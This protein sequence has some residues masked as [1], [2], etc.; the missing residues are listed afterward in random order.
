MDYSDTTVII[1]VKDEP[2]VGKVT[3]EVLSALNNCKVLVIYKGGRDSLN[4]K[5]KD[6]RLSIMQQKG[7]GKGVAVVQ[8]VKTVG[9]DIICFIDG[10]AT[11]DA[12][13]LKKAIK[14]V[15]EGADM[16]IGNRLKDMDRKAMP[17][18]IEFGNRIITETANLLYNMHI[19]DS[20]TGLRAMRRHVFNS[21]NLKEEYFGI[22]TEMNVRCKKAGY[23]IAEAPIK[24]YERIGSS[25]QMKLLDGIKLLLLD[26]KFLSD[27]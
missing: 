10:D 15:R 1:P 20:Q 16:A 4:I 18:Y 22:E 17:F 3:K 12:R 11:Y 27:N 2:A 19:Y 13:D 26:F 5:F 9:T 8:A 7:S 6:K 14:L 25:K 21:L 24:Y 23:Q